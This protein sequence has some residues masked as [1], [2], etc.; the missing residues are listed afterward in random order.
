MRLDND[1]F[2]QFVAGRQMIVLDGYKLRC[3]PWVNKY[4][5]EIRAYFAFS[6]SIQKKWTH[7]QDT[8]HTRWRQTIGIHLRAT[9]FRT[10][11]RGEFYLRPDEYSTILRNQ[12]SI[13]ADETLFVLFSDESYAGDKAYN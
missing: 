9:D 8:W 2:S 3:T 4:A 6:Q 12:P 7:L 5:S 1:A 10:A 11:Q 13:S